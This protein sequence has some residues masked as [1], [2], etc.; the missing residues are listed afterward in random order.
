MH[1][2]FSSCVASLESFRFD[3][4]NLPVQNGKEFLNSC[5]TRNV[6][7]HRQFFWYQIEG[8]G[9]LNKGPI[10]VQSILKEIFYTNNILFTVV[11]EKLL[12]LTIWI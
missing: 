7:N 4:K 11:E 2:S 8:A 5:W 1:L 10:R 9:P 12:I 6:P 3:R